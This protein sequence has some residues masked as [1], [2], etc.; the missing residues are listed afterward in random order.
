MH[1]IESIFASFPD[2]PITLSKS[3]SL[4]LFQPRTQVAIRINVNGRNR[5]SGLLSPR[6]KCQARGRDRESGVSS[7]GFKDQ[8]NDAGWGRL[9]EFERYDIGTVVGGG[10]GFKGIN[11]AVDEEKHKQ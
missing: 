1:R 10:S 11:T 2:Q 7:L 9:E 8:K 3:I 4:A 6:T 5:R